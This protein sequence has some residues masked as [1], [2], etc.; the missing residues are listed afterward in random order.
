MKETKG[1]KWNKMGVK[2]EYFCPKL[3]EISSGKWEKGVLFG[4]I[5]HFPPNNLNDFMNTC[6]LAIQGCQVMKMYVLIQ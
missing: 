1:P 6:I 2:K 5:N 4:K 3:G